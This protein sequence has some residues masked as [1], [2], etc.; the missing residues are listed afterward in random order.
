MKA[1]S[2]YF[3]SESC[4]EYHGGAWLTKP[5]DEELAKFIIHRYWGECEGW[6]LERGK[7]YSWAIENP[8]ETLKICCIN[9][10]LNTFDVNEKISDVEERI[11]DVPLTFD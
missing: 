2:Y 1:Y 5:T 4:D 8:I 6:L 10:R 11:P 7:D 9:P 3:K